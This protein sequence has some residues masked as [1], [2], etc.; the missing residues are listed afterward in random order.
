M[1]RISITKERRERLEKKEVVRPRG[2][3]GGPLDPNNIVFTFLFLLIKAISKSVKIQGV[4][5]R[6][7]VFLSERPLK[8]CTFNNL[9]VPVTRGRDTGV[10]RGTD[11]R[12]LIVVVP[13]PVI[14]FSLPGRVT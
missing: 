2:D 9:Y 14:R 12:A 4:I 8:N 5:R 7:L 3:T 13:S 11:P 10:F 6:F 1:I